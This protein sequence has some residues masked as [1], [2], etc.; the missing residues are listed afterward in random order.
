VRTTSGFGSD[1]PLRRRLAVL[2][3]MGLLVGSSCRSAIALFVCLSN[4]DGRECVLRGVL[5]EQGGPHAPLLV[6]F[7][8]DDAAVFANRLPRVASERWPIAL[9]VVADTGCRT[10]CTADSEA[11]LSIREPER[12]RPE[13]RRSLAE[14][15]R[16]PD[17]GDDGATGPVVP[18][19]LRA[20]EHSTIPGV[21][22][23]EWKH[24]SNRSTP[25]SS[26]S[27]AK[28]RAAS[29]RLETNDEPSSHDP[30]SR[31]IPR[32]ALSVRTA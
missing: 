7:S 24:G 15:P 16:A 17:H 3:H 10:G 9:V 25:R 1:G 5:H 4:F 2:R 12:P 13:G 32:G 8:Q 26:E 19:I 18:R 14:R 27:V 21:S 6:G 31:G 22:A 11:A 28:Q 20:H 30:S 23:F 29:G